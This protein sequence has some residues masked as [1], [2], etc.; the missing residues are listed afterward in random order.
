MFR[1]ELNVCNVFMTL[2]FK[3]FALAGVLSNAFRSCSNV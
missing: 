2:N 3:T 1:G